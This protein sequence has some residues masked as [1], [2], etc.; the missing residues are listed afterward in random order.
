ML[1]SILL[2]GLAAVAQEPDE[3]PV[4]DPV[5]T[6][7]ACA[8]GPDRFL[9]ARSDGSIWL[10][11][12]EDGISPMEV[13]GK[14]GEP[15]EKGLFA[16][17]D[18][19]VS[20]LAASPDLKSVAVS[21]GLNRQ[22]LWPDF[23]SGGRETPILLQGESN[24]DPELEFEFWL[25]F[26]VTPI[27]W[28]HDGRYLLTHRPH[29]VQWWSQEGKLLREFGPSTGVL[30]SP[31]ENVAAIHS[32]DKLSLVRL[33]QEP[34]VVECNSSVGAMDFSPDG[35]RIAVGGKGSRLRIIEV[36]TGRVLL[37]RAVDKVD[38]IFVRPPSAF[39]FNDLR[40]SPDG[41]WIGIS[42]GKGCLPAILSAETGVVEKAIPFSGGRMHE[43][44]ECSWTPDNRLVV[45]MGTTSVTDPLGERDALTWPGLH[46]QIFGQKLG[47][48]AIVLAGPW[49][50]GKRMTCYDLKSG[51]VIW[52]VN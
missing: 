49:D 22:Q 38:T 7:H 28:S 16:R 35:K 17:G 12:G 25:S 46:F 33:D 40:W 31:V 11:D 15:N 37:S 51:K 1:T 8:F 43:P 30:F 26:I 27:Q 14:K 52:A 19:P 48:R 45:G 6:L 47:T 21:R 2:L 4:P 41:K 13:P 32:G 9:A 3:V 34:I 20:H 29:G 44:F 42:L 39:Y 36:A 5:T 18:S 10:L 23:E 50:T 24:A